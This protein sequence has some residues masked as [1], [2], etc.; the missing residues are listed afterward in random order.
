MHNPD[1]RPPSYPNTTFLYMTQLGSLVNMGHYDPALH[2]G[3]ILPL[4][5]DHLIPV[6]QFNTARAM[7][8]IMRIMG[9]DDLYD[10]M[11]QMYWSLMPKNPPPLQLPE[12]LKPT[13]LQL[14]MPHQR[15]ID[16]LPHPMMRDNAIRATGSFI[17]E[18]M[19]C[20]VLGVIF[21]EPGALPQQA[22]NIMVWGEPWLP[23]SYEFSVEFLKKWGFLVKGCDSLLHSTNS[24]RVG[25]GE[26]PLPFWG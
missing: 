16:L 26:A 17:V 24:W 4:S 14:T 11:C 15:W 5:R 22:C 3:T 2:L 13:H 1:Q 9:V 21:D 6:I 8:A 18:E 20:D 19:E 23:E 7:V 25:R 12:A 10:G